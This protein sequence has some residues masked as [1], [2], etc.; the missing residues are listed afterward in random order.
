ML[1][2]F[3]LIIIAVIVLFVSVPVML[4]SFIRSIMSVFTGKKTRTVDTEETTYS[5]DG[6]QEE[7]KVHRRRNNVRKGKKIFDKDEGEYVSFEEVKDEK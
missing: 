7:S 3:I 2:F 4:L 5:N 1:T 6:W